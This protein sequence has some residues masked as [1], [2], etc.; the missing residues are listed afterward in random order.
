MR[1]HLTEFPDIEMPEAILELV[2]DGTLKDMS[3]HNDV[4]P[5]FEV[6]DGSIVLWVDHQDPSKRELAPCKRFAL[7]GDD[8]FD[9]SELLFET[10]DPKELLAYIK[11]HH[12]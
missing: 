5:S 3:W 9:E 4:A 11:D 7:Y 2:K 8:D 6:G 10:D 12:Q 1:T